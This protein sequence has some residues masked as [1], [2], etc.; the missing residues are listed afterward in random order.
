MNRKVYIVTDTE[1]GSNYTLSQEKFS[2]F[3]DNRNPFDYEVKTIEG[4]D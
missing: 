2:R 3:F 1:E 4:E